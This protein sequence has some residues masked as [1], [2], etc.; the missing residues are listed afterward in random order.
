MDR[1]QI[2][3][4]SHLLQALFVSSYQSSGSSVI[5]TNNPRSR[6][7]IFSH[8]GADLGRPPDPDPERLSDLNLA[9]AETSWISSKKVFL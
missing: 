1:R 7:R 4:H 9:Q 5:S 3:A 8:N 6:R 2:I